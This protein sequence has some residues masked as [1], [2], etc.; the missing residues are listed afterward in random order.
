MTVRPPHRAQVVELIV[1]HPAGRR[2]GSGYRVTANVV[3]TATH[4]VEDALSVEVRFA[5][6]LP[7]EWSTIAS[8]WQADPDVDIAV[9]SIEPRADEGPLERAQFG[10]IGDRAAVLEVQAVGF[11]RWKMRNYD[12]TIPIEDDGRPRFRDAEHVVGSMAVLSNW[13]EGTLEVVVP[14]APESGGET[15]P[16]EGM[17]GAAV[18]AAD[19]IIGVIA[20][21]HPGDGP[22]RLTAIRIDRALDGLN[23]EDRP[24]F[25]RALHLPESAQLLA[26]VV[27]PSPQD[28]V[29]SAYRVQL[30]EIAPERLRD[31][32]PELAELVGFC[33]SDQAYAWWQAEPWAG[34]TALLS[35]FA[36]YP[37]AGVRVVSFFIT[38]RFADQSDSA[39]FTDAMIEQLAALNMEMPHLSMAA[40]ARYGHVLRLLQAAAERCVQSGQRLLLLVD[41]LDEDKSRAY[42]GARPS[43]A[44]L[45]PRRPPAGV[46]VLVASRPIPDLPGDVPV[47]HPLRR[48][49]P[50]QLTGSPHAR[51]VEYAARNELARLPEASPLER[52]VLGLLTASRGGLAAPDLE[53]LTGAAPY[54]IEGLLTGAFGRSIASQA[55]AIPGAR[56]P[57]E[58]IYLFAHE[59]LQ[60]T[61]E[62]QYG[63]KVGDYRQ[64]L[65]A[66]AE[67]YRVRGWP[68]ET[69]AYLLS[70]YS[71]VLADAGDI[72]RL[73]TFATDSTRHERMLSLTGGDGQALRQIDT[74]GLVI[75]REPQ[76][77][78]GALLLLVLARHEI[79]SR[80][81][82]VPPDLPAVWVALG[83]PGRAMALAEGITSR[84]FRADALQKVV[85]ALAAAGD[86]DRAARLAAELEAFARGT[87]APESGGAWMLASA[88]IAVA[89]TG[90]L[91]RADR[92][93]DE[94]VRD[95]EAHTWAL[96]ATA[97][98]AVR[99][100][101]GSHVRF[102]EMA[103][104]NLSRPEECARAL[105]M[106]AIAAAAAGDQRYAVELATK[107][108]AAAYEQFPSDLKANTFGVVAAAFT[109]AG[110][111]EHARRLVSPSTDPP[112]LPG[113]LAFIF[114]MAT[115]TGDD[116]LVSRLTAPIQ[117]SAWGQSRFALA[118]AAAGD[119]PQAR[120]EATT[121]GSGAREIADPANR[122][123][124]LSMVAT[125]LAAAGEPVLA[126]EAAMDAESA[127]RGIDDPAGQVWR[128]GNLAAALATAGDDVRV[129]RIVTIAKRIADSVPNATERKTVS[130]ALG[131]YLTLIRRKAPLSEL[132]YANTWWFEQ[133]LA[134]ET[135]GSSGQPKDLFHTGHV[136]LPVL[137][138]GCDATL[139]RISRSS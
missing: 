24:S 19:H 89:A 56:R 38:T 114:E 78:L 109:A 105:S 43:I 88:A 69:P 36:L 47:D 125:A 55:D 134:A 62:R 127:A 23:P 116:K 6:D 99:A 12:G 31:R 106:L 26:D 13:R 45:L 66:W 104:G 83:D 79:L 95:P 16:W 65:H 57:G 102:A 84:V 44:S 71:Q 15:S 70:G 30:A 97:E 82:H 34:K 1:T 101:R 136:D 133:L 91:E 115:Q 135:T 87:T 54:E 120:A 126:R 68:P 17:S 63:A 122:A 138:S 110:D 20:K 100:G 124:A 14:T 107:A 18:W 53:E 51:D 9:V 10:R 7:G 28:L 49:R 4:V 50:R 77:D 119:K 29:T 37:P 61:A 123:Q 117:P 98:A 75:A 111:I 129:E 139:A 52:D 93:R 2:R 64:R 72:P 8:A 5:P 92:L 86:H 35:W 58:R 81:E 40:G 39:V 60:D 76:P 80:N 103:T 130:G 22:A 11:P 118:L 94:N 21:H 132:P 131:Y 85:S 112:P 48:T 27:P 46:R 108:K 128:L 67:D 90:D 74:A 41:G 137:Q 3:L 73:V 25:T 33:A 59:S 42:G 96:C 121:A 113:L 32:D